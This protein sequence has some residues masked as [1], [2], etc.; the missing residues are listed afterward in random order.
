MARRRALVL[1]ASDFHF[2]LDFLHQVLSAFA[3][4]DVV[5]VVIW[6][7]A[8]FARLPRFGLVELRDAESGRRRTVLMRPWLRERWREAFAQRR[9]A[10]MQC[11]ARHALRPFLITGRFDADA[12]T[13]HFFG[14]HHGTS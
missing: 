3:A 12:L 13:D 6:D 4:H 14:Q 1:L 10:L 8:E 11:F 7:E 2:P 5:P 9:A